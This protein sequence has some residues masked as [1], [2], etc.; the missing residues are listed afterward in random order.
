MRKILGNRMKSRVDAREELTIPTYSL[1]KP[2]KKIPR[3]VLIGTLVVL[4]IFTTIYLPPM[5]I[6][7]PDRTTHASVNLTASA[8]PVAMELAQSYMRNHPEGDFDNDGLTNEEELDAGTGIYIVDNDFDGVSDYAEL[9]LTETNPTVAD[10][11]I[12]KFVINAD[13]KT[14]NTVNTPFKV[15]D[16]VLWADD[17]ESKARGSVVKLPD[18]SYNFY[19]FQGWVQ[20]PEDVAYAYEVDNGIQ[21]ALRKNE[22]GYF[23]IDSPELKNVRIY[24]EQPEA[25]YI[26]S[27][28]GNRFSV[29]DNFFFKFL[30][31]IFPSQGMGLITCRPALA[32]DLDGTWDEVSVTNEKSQY[33]ASSFPN[34]RFGYDQRLLTDL[35]GIM[36]EI[37][38]GNNVI[39]SLM[40]HQVGEVIVE[41]YGYTSRNNLLVCDPSTGEDLG[42]INIDILPERVLD[43]SGSIEEYEHF[44]FEGC[45]YS[46]ESRHRIVILDYVR[47]GESVIYQ[48]EI[49]DPS[50]EEDDEEAVSPDAE[51]SDDTAD[52]GSA[53]DTANTDGS[54][55]DSTSPDE[56]NTE[57]ETANDDGK[58]AAEGET[59]AEDA[60]QPEA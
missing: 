23:Y 14:G 59:P 16:V 20:F 2:K 21:T 25:C 24:A 4:L 51:S 26:I 13:S 53:T 7:E 29:P 15:H 52:D 37:D 41:V 48:E 17:Y 58:P 38:S 35:S 40:S 34:E 10:D 46:S 49:E 57:D 56:Q 32:N 55:E 3:P 9:Y 1:I 45:G 28:L 6:E 42:V 18:G 27:L 30:S 11:G 44:A 43:K 22:S 50:V 8:D 39:I 31:W 12:I 54:G 60:V 36:A 47:E 5:L 19:R 33:R